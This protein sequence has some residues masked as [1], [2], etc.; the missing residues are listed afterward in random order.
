[1]DCSELQVHRREMGGCPVH[2]R[3]AEGRTTI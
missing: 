1:L 2:A 3:F